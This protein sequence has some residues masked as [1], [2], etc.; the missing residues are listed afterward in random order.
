M[1]SLRNYHS[2]QVLTVVTKIGYCNTL[3]KILNLATQIISKYRPWRLPIRFS[4]NDP[5]NNKCCYYTTYSN[6]LTPFSSR[7]PQK[8][9]WRHLYVL[10]WGRR[11]R[12]GRFRPFDKWNRLNSRSRRAT[13]WWWSCGRYIGTPFGKLRFFVLYATFVLQLSLH[14]K[15]KAFTSFRWPIR[16]HLANAWFSSPEDT[17]GPSNMTFCAQ[18][19]SGLQLQRQNGEVKHCR[20][21]M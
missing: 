20:R 18:G 4:I 9:I 1:Y 17:N 2:F 13:H 21:L 11:E 16:W 8:T 5:T 7:R 15:Y 6:K 12:I 19:V 14:I 10:S 3:E